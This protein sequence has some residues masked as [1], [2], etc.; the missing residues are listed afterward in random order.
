MIDTCPFDAPTAA[1]VRSTEGLLYFVWEREAIR[2]AREN[3]IMIEMWTADPIFQKYKFT[4]IR[5]RDDRVS[6]WVIEHLIEPAVDDGDQHLWFTLLV[7]RLINWPPTLSRLIAAGVIPCAPHEFDAARFESVLESAKAHGKVYSGAYMLYPTKMEPGGNKS[8]AVAKY[9]LGSAVAHADAID[10]AMWGTCETHHS[11]ER[12]VEALSQCFGISTFIAGQV[13][14]DLTYTELYF[15]DLYTYAPIGPGSSRG[16][17]YLLSRGPSATWSQG[18]FNAELIRLRLEIIE[19][20]KITDMTLHDV[21]N[22]MCEFSKYC[23][24]V[25]GEGVPKSTY[26]PETE[27]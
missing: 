27:F 10:A 3:G 7:A 18:A 26:K 11:V 8:R 20:L 24:T 22:C 9:I 25:L 23:R 1:N 6:Q 17:N 13:A 14:A 4:N 19:H 15:D 16:L 5:R 21:Q 12:L 2:Q